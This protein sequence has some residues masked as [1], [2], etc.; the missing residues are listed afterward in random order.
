[1]VDKPAHGDVYCEKNFPHHV[2]VEAVEVEDRRRVD[3]S[4]LAPPVSPPLLIEA[5]DP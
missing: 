2:A 3:A 1:V 4:V 5:S